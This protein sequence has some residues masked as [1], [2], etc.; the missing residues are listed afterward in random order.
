MQ[1][2]N[3]MSRT[4][5]CMVAPNMATSAISLHDAIILSILQTHTRLHYRVGNVSEC[6]P[7]RTAGNADVDINGLLGRCIA[8]PKV[9]HRQST[10]SAK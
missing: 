1:R 2:L 8:R 10:F 4:V 5:M 6:P 7:R 9:L 3:A